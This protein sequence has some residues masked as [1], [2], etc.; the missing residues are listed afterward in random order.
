MKKIRKILI[1]D[2]WL[3]SY[4]HDVVTRCVWHTASAPVHLVSLCVPSRRNRPLRLVVGANKPD[5]GPNY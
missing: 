1:L 4:M 5:L 2:L 3:M